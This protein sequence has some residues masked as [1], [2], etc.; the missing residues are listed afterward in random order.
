MTLWCA[1]LP[2]ASLRD[3]S[4]EEIGILLSEIGSCRLRTV[5]L[6]CALPVTLLLSFSLTF[7]VGML[8]TPQDLLFQLTDLFA[9]LLLCIGI[10]VQLILGWRWA[11]RWRNLGLDMRSGRVQRFEGVLDEAFPL[12]HTQKNLLAARLLLLDATHVQW[13]E[14]LPSSRMVWRVNGQPPRSWVGAIASRVASTPE[15]A[16]IAA[17]WLEPVARSAEGVIYGGQ[18]ELSSDE[19]TEILHHVHRLWVRPLT[20]SIPLLLLLIAQ[21]FSLFHQSN[22]SSHDHMLTVFV[23]GAGLAVFSLSFVFR[24][25][26]ARR[27]TRDLQIGY[28]AIRRVDGAQREPAPTTSEAEIEFLPASGMLWTKA[29]QPAIWRRA[30]I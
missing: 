12:D 14:V 2:F 9:L 15:F 10:P 30:D 22:D 1:G 25:R 26:Q 18:R 4:S 23:M 5:V 6:I 8:R 7:I 20:S 11:Q 29:G 3:L 27:F 19:K 16:A 17:Q 21:I 28:V 13:V 24:A